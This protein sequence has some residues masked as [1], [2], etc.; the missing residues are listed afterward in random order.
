MKIISASIDLMKI[1]KNKIV[2]GKMGQKYF[3]IQII[4]G[5]EKDKYGN[6]CSVCINQTKDERERKEK[7][8]YLGNGKTVWDSEQKEAKE[9]NNEPTDL[10]F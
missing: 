6:D 10:P 4:V 3:N 9:S 7:R 1:D 8:V 5:D 2:L